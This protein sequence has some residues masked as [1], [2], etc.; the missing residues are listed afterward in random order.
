MHK[1]SEDDFVFLQILLDIL[2][3]GMLFFF[4][5][6]DP[7]NDLILIIRYVVSLLISKVRKPLTFIKKYNRHSGSKKRYLS[8]LNK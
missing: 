3:V 2:Y 8:F 5:S 6:T 1:E 4:Q 7:E